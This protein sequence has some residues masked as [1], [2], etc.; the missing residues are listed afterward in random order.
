VQSNLCIVTCVT[1]GS[2]LIHTR[3]L[4][5]PFFRLFL[6][7]ILLMDLQILNS[8]S[9]LLLRISND[10]FKDPR[11]TAMSLS[12]VTTISYVLWRLSSSPEPRPSNLPP[13]VPYSIPYVGNGLELR[14]DARAFITQ[15]KEKYGPIFQ[16]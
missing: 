7:L 16:M 2:R 11:S 8:T 9:K 5:Q 13:I 12:A 15:C 14:R 6:F 1:S 10:F 4:A 3:T